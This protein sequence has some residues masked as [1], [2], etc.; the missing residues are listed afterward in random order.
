MLMNSLMPT[1]RSEPL[2]LGFLPS[3]E[4]LVERS[5]G[6]IPSEAGLWPMRLFDQ[7]VGLYRP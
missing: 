1:L 7:P 3:R 4:L 6:Q 5:A 2:L